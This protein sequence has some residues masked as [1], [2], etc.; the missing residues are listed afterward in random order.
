MYIYA[1]VLNYILFQSI[2]TQYTLHVLCSKK[3]YIYY[4]CM[5]YYYIHF[6][7]ITLF[8]MYYCCHFKYSVCLLRFYVVSLLYTRL[9]K[10]S[11]DELMLP[12]YHVTHVK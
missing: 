12:N 8:Y 6:V 1:N 9:S 2:L 10:N 4:T 5:Y 3:N 11:S 7:L